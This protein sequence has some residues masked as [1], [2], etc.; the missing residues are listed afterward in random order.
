MASVPIVD[1]VIKWYVKYSIH[2]D[3]PFVR[4]I[5]VTYFC[6]FD[7]IK[8]KLQ[9]LSVCNRASLPVLVAEK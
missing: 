2:R 6:K 4:T 3:C 5:L 1:Q 9:F 8:V 7:G